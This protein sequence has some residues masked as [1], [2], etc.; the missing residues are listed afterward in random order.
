MSSSREAA[1]TLSL[2]DSLRTRTLANAYRT[3]W[4]IWLLWAVVYAASVPVFTSAPDWG[5]GLYWLCAAPIA[6]VATVITFR[7]LTARQGVVPAERPSAIVGR[8]VLLIVACFATAPLTP[9]G[10]WLAV[11]V[12]IVVFGWVWPRRLAFAVAVALAASAVVLELLL[13]TREAAAATAATYAVAFVALAL[14]ERRRLA[15]LR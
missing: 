2:L 6:V 7:R 9:V 11:A 14:Y 1:E 12:A 10:A 3:A 4:M 8:G 13:E 15:A 5:I